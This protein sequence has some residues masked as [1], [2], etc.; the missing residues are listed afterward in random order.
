MSGNQ[1]VETTATA[2]RQRGRGPIWLLLLAVIAIAGGLA[3]RSGVGLQTPSATPANA[4]AGDGADA[5]DPVG[6]PAAAIKALRREQRDLAQRLSDVTGSQQVLR[7]E[8]LGVGDRAALL[9]QSVARIASPRGQGE[10]ALRLDE[11]E[12]LLTIGQQQVELAADVDGALRAYAL[13][14][15]VLAGSTDPSVVNLRQP[16]AQEM[17]AL[18]ALPPDPR[19]VLGSR[20]DAFESSLAAPAFVDTAN[21]AVQPASLFDRVVGSMVEV[22]HAQARDLLDPTRREAALTAVQMEVTLARLALE[23]RDADAFHA[24]VDRIAGWL[25]RLYSPA[26]VARQRAQLDAMRELPLRIAVPSLGATLAELRRLRL[27]QPPPAPATPEPAPAAAR[28]PAHGATHA[29]KRGAPS[30]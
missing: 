5:G 23:R 15:G 7:E 24:A 12:L 28:T 30:R 29:G 17:A 14:D 11:A 27:E 8:V 3:W 22:H 25:P 19:R 16:L 21:T 2:R 18:R 20:L 10:Q 13:A 4:D 9:E 1:S 6:D 26:T